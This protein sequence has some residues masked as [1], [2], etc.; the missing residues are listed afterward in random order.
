M[1]RV[2]NKIC[3][4][5]GAAGGIGR[6]SA[7]A[8]AAEGAT[9]YVSDSDALRARSVASEAGGHALELDV[10][11]EAHWRAAIDA[12]LTREGRLDVLVNNAGRFLLEPLATTTLTD[13]RALSAVNVDGVFLGCRYGV[14]AMR[15]SAREGEPARG[16]I[17]NIASYLGNIGMARASA[18]CATKGAVRVLTKSV[19][20]ECG[21]R[22]E[23]IRVNSVHPGITRTA[24]TERLFPAEAWE[25]PRETFARVPMGTWCTPEDVAAAVVFLA[26]EESAFITGTELPVDAGMTAA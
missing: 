22:G 6:A 7:L 17:V 9:V 19:A 23:F 12:L 18:Y 11:N 10:A 24:M 20:V 14:E 13:F 25:A 15:R 4:I 2:A 26:S 3:L 16:S 1:N 8:L 5:T 21:S